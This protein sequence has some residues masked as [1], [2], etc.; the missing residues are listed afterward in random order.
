LFIDIE[1]QFKKAVRQIFNRYKSRPDIITQ[2]KAIRYPWRKLFQITPIPGNQIVGDIYPR[3]V[4]EI[5]VHY[6]GL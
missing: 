3:Y 2:P 1:G 4:E 6:A 5:D